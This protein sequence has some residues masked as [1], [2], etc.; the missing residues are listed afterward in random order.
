M[1][2][3]ANEDPQVQHVTIFSI[4]DAKNFGKH[5]KEETKKENEKVSRVSKF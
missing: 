5:M 1:E 3:V 2:E 4:T